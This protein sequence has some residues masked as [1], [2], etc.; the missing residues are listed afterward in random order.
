MS[1]TTPIVEKNSDFLEWAEKELAKAEKTVETASVAHL[2][3][4]AAK[5]A[6][7]PIVY[8]KD[9]QKFVCKS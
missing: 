8:G 4:L 7:F 1:N 3:Y 2:E 9:W 6:T 5:W